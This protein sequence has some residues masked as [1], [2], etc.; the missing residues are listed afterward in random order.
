MNTTLEAIDKHRQLKFLYD[1]KE[2]F[3]QSSIGFSRNGL[4]PIIGCFASVDGN[5]INIA[6]C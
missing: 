5:P 6:E 4:R 3:E 2:W 1:A